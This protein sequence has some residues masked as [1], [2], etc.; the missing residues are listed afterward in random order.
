ME[1]AGR[2]VYKQR[3]SYDSPWDLKTKTLM[4]AWE[5]CWGLLCSWT[6]KPFNPWRLLWLRLFGA[7]IKGR[8]FVHQRARMAMPWS[9][10]LHDRVTLGDRSELYSLGVI[11]VGARAIVAQ[12]AYLCGATHDFS[13][14]AL[15]LVTAKI[16]VG[17]DVFIGARAFV[18]PGVTIGSGALIGAGAVVTKD[19]P[20]SMVCVG[21][22]CKPIKP[23]PSVS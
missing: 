14:P 23:R 9:V 21:N 17:E 3:L 8:P 2:H 18:M 15:P 5:L 11:E 10:I 7:Q 19:L 16:T 20:A 12:E 1:K 6:S 22:P 4:I 13:D